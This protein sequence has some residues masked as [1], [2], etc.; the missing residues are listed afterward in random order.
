MPNQYHIE[1]KKGSKKLRQRTPYPPQGFS[2][3]QNLLNVHT[4]FNLPSS[5]WGGV[6]R[7][8]NSKKGQKTLIFRGCE[9]VQ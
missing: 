9:G 5:I 3:V 1:K 4:K 8:T 2:S 7:G 6:M